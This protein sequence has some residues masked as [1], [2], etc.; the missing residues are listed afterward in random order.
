M[1]FEHLFRNSRYLYLKSDR[2][3]KIDTM[4]RES[5]NFYKIFETLFHLIC[6]AAT[7]GTTSWCFYIF[8]L[9]KDVCLVDFKEFG[10]EKEYIYP[11]FSLVFANP[12]IEGKLKGYGENITTTSYV[13]FLKGFH[14]DD[15]MVNISYDNVTLDINDYFLGYNILMADME[16]RYYNKSENG[17]KLFSDYLDPKTSARQIVYMYYSFLGRCK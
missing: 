1:N 12:F 14:W 4:N 6:I 8:I 15:R 3:K 5:I 9:D 10:E 16:I 11:S 13:S 7:I 2:A 17:W